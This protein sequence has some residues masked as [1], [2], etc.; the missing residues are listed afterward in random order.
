MLAGLVIERERAVVHAQGQQQGVL[1]MG[2]EGLV[3]RLL[4]DISREAEAV[5]IVGG[6]QA[7]G[8]QALRF[9]EAQVIAE[10]D[11]GIWEEGSILEEFDIEPGGMGEEV[12]ECD[13]FG[14]GWLDVELSE[15][16]V[17]VVVEAER[18][19]IGLLQDGERG[20]DFRDG[21]YAK[22]R[23]G[24][25]DGLLGLEVGEAEALLDDRLSAMNN[26]D[27]GARNAVLFDGLG[28]EL[29]G[30]SAQLLGVERLRGAFCWRRG[31][32]CQRQAQGQQPLQHSK[33]GRQ[34]SHS[35]VSCIRD[36]R[37]GQTAHCRNSGRTPGKR[38]GVRVDLG[39]KMGERV[40][41]CW[42]RPKHRNS[43][44]PPTAGLAD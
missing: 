11:A 29:R 8:A 35:G 37:G 43:E 1:H 7:G 19:L 25:L 2:G 13:G 22:E 5:I 26:G 30:E 42:G 21:G 12:V 6:E 4:D 20:E 34:E 31:E 28:D 23:V 3:G 15:V 33:M 32:C 14:E 27:R 38:R 16:V 44:T 17:D 39:R 41:G 10:R 40:A 36:C 9:V 18:A 24:G